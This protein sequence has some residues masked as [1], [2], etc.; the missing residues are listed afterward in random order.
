MVM[1]NRLET[2]GFLILFLV[3]SDLQFSNLFI[4]FSICL[5]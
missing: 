2:A 3:E 1:E 4:T 5:P